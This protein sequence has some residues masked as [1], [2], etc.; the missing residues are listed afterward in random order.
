MST[1]I[2]PRGKTVALTG[3]VLSWAAM[4]LVVVAMAYALSSPVRIIGFLPPDLIDGAVRL[5][6]RTWMW[7]GLVLLVTFAVVS[8]CLV[9]L[10]RLFSAIRQGDLF[11]E[12]LERTLRRLGIAA[13]VSAVGAII[14]R[15]LMAYILKPLTPTGQPRLTVS[16]SSD[17]IFFALIAIFLFL[18]ALIVREARRADA[19]NR[20]FI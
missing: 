13:M 1:E 6:D 5:D 4:A 7:A 8:W 2:S 18:F 3:E 12:R 10:A 20:G 15:T 14:Q 16:L 11:G 9:E 17:D 19:E